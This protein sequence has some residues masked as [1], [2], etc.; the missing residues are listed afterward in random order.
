MLACLDACYHATG[1]AMAACVLFAHWTDST[2]LQELLAASPTAAPYRPGAFYLRELPCLLT[3]IRQCPV[4]PDILIIDGY[5]WLDA[6]HR[7][8]LGARLHE[9]LHR[10]CAV[11][12]VAKTAFVGA[13]ALPIS[14]GTAKRPLFVTAVGMDP[15]QAAVQIAAMHGPHRIPTL[16][17]L[18]DQL[19]RRPP[20][21]N[22]L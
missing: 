5:V 7:P 20:P 6:H 4:L 11:V 18:A 8:G 17:R 21:P 13:P 22:R 15:H 3:V 2:P 19:C 14:R 9:A 1:S 10:R 12:G 16:I